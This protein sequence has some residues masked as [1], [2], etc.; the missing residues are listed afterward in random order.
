MATLD[1][2]PLVDLKPID[3]RQDDFHLP[4]RAGQNRPPC[5]NYNLPKPLGP[6]RR[7]RWILHCHRRTRHKWNPHRQSRWG[8][9]WRML[10]LHVCVCLPFEP[11]HQAVHCQNPCLCLCNPCRQLCLFRPAIRTQPSS[12]LTMQSETA[13]DKNASENLLRISSAQPQPSSKRRRSDR[14]SNQHWLFL[15]PSLS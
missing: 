8:P 9:S 10:V 5:P 12:F 13:I 15:P 1:H 14:A 11:S 3:L 6:A 2:Q 7:H 4:D